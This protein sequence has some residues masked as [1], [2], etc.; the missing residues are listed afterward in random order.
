MFTTFGSECLYA[1]LQGAHFAGEA[2]I[3]LAG[4]PK[5]SQVEG[6]L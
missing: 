2:L 3:V 4:L 6:L 1:I 5:L